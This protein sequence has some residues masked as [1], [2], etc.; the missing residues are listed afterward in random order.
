MVVPIPGGTV[1]VVTSGHGDEWSVGADVEMGVDQIY[2]TSH[3][4]GDGGA[5]VV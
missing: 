3:R 5:D 4:L 2:I 1:Q